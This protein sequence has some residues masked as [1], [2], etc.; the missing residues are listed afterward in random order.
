MESGLGDPTEPDHMEL[1]L[2]KG[3][4]TRVVQSPV[5]YEPCSELKWLP[6]QNYHIKAH[7]GGMKGASQTVSCLPQMETFKL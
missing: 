5:A 1:S 4:V 2:H 3:R 6:M 7:Q